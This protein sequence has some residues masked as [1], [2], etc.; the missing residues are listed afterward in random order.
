MPHS[1]ASCQLSK[2]F[3]NIDRHSDML[4]ISLSCFIFKIKKARFSGHCFQPKK[5]QLYN[6]SFI[7]LKKNRVKANPSLHF[8]KQSLRPQGQDSC[9][10]TIVLTILPSAR[11]FTLGV[12]AAITFPMSFMVV[13]PTS[14]IVSS[15][16]F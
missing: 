8:F 11:P 1:Y 5:S 14:F 2:P 3:M 6:N 12:S 7:L 16:I 10:L 15:T 13:A 9:F 4:P